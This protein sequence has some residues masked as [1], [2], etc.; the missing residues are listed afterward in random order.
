[1]LSVGFRSF[2]RKLYLK[3]MHPEP[4][5]YDNSSIYFVEFLQRQSVMSADMGPGF[6]KVLA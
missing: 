2:L 6:F 3:I 1:M 5:C 4:F